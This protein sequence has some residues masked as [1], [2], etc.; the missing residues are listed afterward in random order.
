MAQFLISL[1]RLIIGLVKYPTLCP[2]Q[3]KIRLKP[4]ANRTNP[5]LRLSSMALPPI[6]NCH[7]FCVVFAN[8]LQ[9]I[10]ILVPAVAKSCP[11]T[12][13]TKQKGTALQPP[14]P[15]RLCQYANRWKLSYIMWHYSTFS[16]RLQATTPTQKC[17]IIT[18]CKIA[19]AI[20]RYPKKYP[21]A[22]SPRSYF[23]GIGSRIF[24]SQRLAHA[25]CHAPHHPFQRCRN[26]KA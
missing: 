17:P 11:N 9:H 12:Q 6:C 15:F 19:N 8:A 20:V 23:S 13:K 2:R 3:E 14:P 18:L 22:P 16:P 21:N 25:S 10:A 24:S 4:G 26:K 1:L 7:T 5:T